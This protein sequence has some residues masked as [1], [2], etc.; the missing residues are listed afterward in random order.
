MEPDYRERDD[1][2]VE[3]ST[4]DGGKGYGDVAACS[5]NGQS[6]TGTLGDKYIVL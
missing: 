5:G 6:R 3:A 1:E 4:G 2:L